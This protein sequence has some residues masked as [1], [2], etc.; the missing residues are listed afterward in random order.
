M[1]G[2]HG[3][4]NMA[5]LPGPADTPFVHGADAVGALLAQKARQFGVAQ[6]AP[7]LERVVVMMRPVIGRLG[8]ERN[9]DRHLRHH[10]GAAAPDQAAVGE[11]H[12]AAGARGLD[13]GIQAGGAGADHQDVGFGA[14]RIVRHGRPRGESR[15]Q[16]SIA[17]IVFATGAGRA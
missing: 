8:A 7:G 1:S 6:S 3:L 9:R 10:G 4:R 14:H 16:L 11:Q 17:T 2:G 5:V 12:V 13:R 15:L